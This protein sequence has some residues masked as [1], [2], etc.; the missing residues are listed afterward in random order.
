MRK[1]TDAPPSHALSPTRRR[2]LALGAGALASPQI[3]CRGNVYSF[4]HDGQR[5]GFE[6]RYQNHLS[7][8]HT[9][10][11]LSNRGAKIDIDRLLPQLDTAI[12]T[13]AKG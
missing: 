11:L 5:E 8:N 2:V 9:V 4:G 1:M 7:N 12:Q 13:Y 6:T 3:N 10:V